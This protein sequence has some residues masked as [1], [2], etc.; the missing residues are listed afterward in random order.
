EYDSQLAA[1]VNTP[2]SQEAPSPQ[3]VPAVNS[4]SL[5]PDKG[6]LRSLQTPAHSPLPHVPRG[7]GS[8]AGTEEQIPGVAPAQ[9]RQRWPHQE[10]QQNPSTQWPERQSPATAHSS[11]TSATVSAPISQISPLC[12]I[13]LTVSVSWST[14]TLNGHSM[15]LALLCI[16][17]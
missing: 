17:S 8:P 3:G 10:S 11:P 13:I 5:V 15:L 14:K 16:S 7:S 9:V 12:V 1:G 2:S 6:S 4:H